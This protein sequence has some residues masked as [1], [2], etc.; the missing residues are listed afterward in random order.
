[1]E[2]YYPVFKFIVN[3]YGYGD[4]TILWVVARNYDEAYDYVSN[5]DSYRIDLD[6]S[7]KY[8]VSTSFKCYVK[9]ETCL[10]YIED[11]D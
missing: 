9:D 11:Q 2:N 1:M 6:Y 7:D 3:N 8:M 5:D 10:P 4:K